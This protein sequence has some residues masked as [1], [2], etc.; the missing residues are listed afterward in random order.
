MQSRWNDTDAALA[1]AEAKAAGLPVRLGLRAYT[2]RLLGQD[3]DLAPHGGDISVKIDDAEGGAVIHVSTP[4]MDLGDIA[5]SDLPA[6][7]LA[8]LLG[9]HDAADGD[10]TRLR[11]AMIDPKAPAPSAR[12]LLHAGLPHAF[13]DHTPATAILALADQPDMAATVAAVFG[14]RLAFVPNAP[15]LL[16]ACL[17]ACEANPQAEGLWLAQRGLLTFGTTARESYERTIR[18]VT[19]AEE[20]LAARG[21]TL[22]GPEATDLSP[23]DNLAYHL[24]EALA[25]QGSLGKPALDFRSSP[26]IRRWLERADL[27]ELIHRGP[28]SPD[29]AARLR[30]FCMILPPDANL[31]AIR[32]ALLD[33]AQD[34]RAC[35]DRHAPATEGERAI[36]DPLPRAVLVPGLGAYGIGRDARAATI[37][38]DLLE[39]TARIVNAAEDYGRFTPITGAELF[40]MDLRP[41]EPA[42]PKT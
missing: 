8:P 18:F 36:P 15:G 32:L 31:T 19:L 25:G 3:A 16:P 5:A 7:R 13:V 30:P 41:P 33:F 24:T 17:A 28:A 42:R 22:P 29:H 21:V 2:A 35:L 12:A 10:G 37:A 23:P 26:S 34:Y 6:L 11:E 27:S 38:G 20:H 9:V 40:A 4:G 1:A 14:G 39:Q